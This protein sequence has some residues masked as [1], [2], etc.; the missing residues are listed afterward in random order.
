MNRANQQALF[1]AT[2]QGLLGIRQQEINYYLNLNL[3]FG[4]QAALIGGFTYGVFTQNQLNQENDYGEVFFDICWI[5]SA[6]TIA[7]AVH[8]IVNTMLLQVVGPG[9]ALHG[10]VGSIVRATE[11]MKVEQKQIVNAFI[12]MMMM[13]ALSTI[14]SFWV[15]MNFESALGSTA[16]F[17]IAA[18]QWYFYT[19]RIYLRFY[20]DADKSAWDDRKEDDS[21]R[22]PG[23][24][25]ERSPPNVVE[26]KSTIFISFLS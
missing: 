2:N 10:P 15:V 22:E 9:L 17:I 13:F 14:M 7:S 24:F 5:M 21:G 12:L 1:Q 18:R 19:E 16:V 26:R 25:H 3:A 11:G 6:A 4:T 20:W 8:V 23:N